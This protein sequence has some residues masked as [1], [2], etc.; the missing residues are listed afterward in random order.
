MDK[1]TIKDFKKI[2][3]AYNKILTLRHKFNVK[4]LC[5][6]LD[7]FVDYLK[8]LR[9]F[10]IMIDYQ[11]QNERAELSLTALIMAIDEYELYIG[12][13]LSQPTME[14]TVQLIKEGKYTEAQELHQKELEQHWRKFWHL[15]ELNIEEWFNVNF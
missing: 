2:K 12:C 5:N 9:D 7:Y 11:E 14:T 4:N 1:S 10:L 8:Y 3:K 13:L 15:I 6:P